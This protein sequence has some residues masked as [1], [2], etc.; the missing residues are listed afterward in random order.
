MSDPRVDPSAENN[1]A[2]LIASIKGH[3]NILKLLLKDPRVDPTVNNN[4]IIRSAIKQ[5]NFDIVILLLGCKNVKKYLIEKDIEL[6][7]RIKKYDVKNK[8]NNF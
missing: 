1:F 4:E 2:I 6:Y 5:G 8:V 3:L 7:N